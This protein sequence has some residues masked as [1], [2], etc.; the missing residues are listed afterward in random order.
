MRS[1]APRPAPRVSVR[2]GGKAELAA[3]GGTAGTCRAAA[4][5]SRVPCRT[6]SRRRRGV[7]R[8]TG[9]RVD[10][11]GC[12]TPPSAARSAA[13]APSPR[14]AARCRAT[15]GARLAHRPAAA[16][17][18]APRG[19]R[20]ERGR[21]EPPPAPGL[22]APRE[23]ACPGEWAW[24][25]RRRRRGGGGAG[26]AGKGRRRRPRRRGDGGGARPGRP[27]AVAAAAGAAAAAAVS[28]GDARRS[29]RR[30][31]TGPT[32]CCWRW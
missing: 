9:P 24:P 23:G 27:P 21:A 22:G 11:R 26:A 2:R 8:V 6:G 18:R 14:G 15:L 7:R 13:A 3:T 12:G 32:R 19:P 17:H 10:S 25:G 1:A 20:P 28:G 31:R 29:R 30:W 5:N 4:V 16:R